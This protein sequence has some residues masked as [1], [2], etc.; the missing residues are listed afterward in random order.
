MS[1]T[2]SF[3]LH[4]LLILTQVAMATL[5]HEGVTRSSLCNH[6]DRLMTAHPREVL[7]SALQACPVSL[8]I[9]PQQAEVLEFP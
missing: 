9:F 1:K 4:C 5:E 8:T 7:A 3:G 2:P 6:G